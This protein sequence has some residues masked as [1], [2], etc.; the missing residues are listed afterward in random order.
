MTDYTDGVFYCS[1]PANDK[2]DGRYPVA[3][4]SITIESASR[5]WYVKNPV[6]L[7][8]DKGTLSQQSGQRVDNLIYTILD[9]D[10]KRQPVPGV[11]LQ[12]RR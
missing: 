1:D 5:C 3:Q 7:T 10:A 6:N 11:R 9:E 2:P 4:A 12:T 8:V